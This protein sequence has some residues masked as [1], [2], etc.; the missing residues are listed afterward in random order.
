MY[1]DI[2]FAISYAILVNF[3]LRN[4]FGAEAIHSH[5]LLFCLFSF[6]S[7]MGPQ[8]ITEQTAMSITEASLRSRS[9]AS[10][11]RPTAIHE[12]QQQTNRLV[13]FL[14]DNDW[15]ANLAQTSS[16]GLEVVERSASHR[17][18]AILVMKPC[19]TTLEQAS[20]G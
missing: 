19:S 14:S 1:I 11:Q 7:T 20:F 10:T 6:G 4:L 3:S 9:A 13:K 12:P 18:A 5:E 2:C 15:S 17:V 8:E 16:A